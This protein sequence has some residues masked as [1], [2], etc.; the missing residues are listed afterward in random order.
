MYL[1]HECPSGAA[2]DGHQ[3]AETEALQGLLLR[4]LNADVHKF[5]LDMISFFY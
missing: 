5:H 3:E 2:Q 4:A 1:P